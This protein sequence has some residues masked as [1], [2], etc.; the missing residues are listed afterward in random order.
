MFLGKQS[1][2]VV[3]VDANLLALAENIP[4]FA[5][6]LVSKKLFKIE[7]NCKEVFRI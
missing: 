7:L 2:C 3:I 4:H 5:F 1:S 6:T